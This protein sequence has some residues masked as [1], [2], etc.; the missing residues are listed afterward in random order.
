MRV[1]KTAD[2]IRT[3]V[4]SA[5]WLSAVCGCG[6]VPSPTDSGQDIPSITEDTILVRIVNRT[7]RPLDPQIYVG[8]IADGAGELFQAA[9][10][11]VGFGVWG[12]GILTPATSEASF[13]VACG[14]SVYI[15]TR[16]GGYG[17]DLTAP[18]DQGRSFIFEE[19]VNVHCGDMLVFSF[20][21]NEGQLITSVAVQAGGE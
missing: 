13:A 5:A 11:R 19:E 1:R 16:G 4:V 2:A 7:E 20:G 3:L 12:V 17:D 15:G 21:V 6:L 18:A 14:E 9:N 10:K 8:P